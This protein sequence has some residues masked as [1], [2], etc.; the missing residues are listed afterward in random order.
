MNNVK[1]NLI[2]L[3]GNAFALLGAFSREAKKQ[4]WTEEQIETVTKEAKKGS[5]NHLLCTLMDNIE[6]PDFECEGDD[7]EDEEFDDE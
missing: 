4:G 1:M 2:G 7:D 3:D 6:E 5:Y